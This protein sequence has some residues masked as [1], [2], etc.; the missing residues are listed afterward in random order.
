M[1]SMPFTDR[2]DLP[3]LVDDVVP[4]LAAVGFNVFMG[5]EHGVREPIGSQTR[6]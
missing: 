5:R 1:V 4:R 2:H 6:R 3:G